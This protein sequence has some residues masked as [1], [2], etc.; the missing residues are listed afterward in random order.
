MTRSALSKE[1]Y[2]QELFNQ[3][4]EEKMSQYLLEIIVYFIYIL[5]LLFIFITILRTNDYK[6]RK[7]ITTD[8]IL[9]LG[10]T[11]ITLII[12][13]GKTNGILQN[14]DLSVTKLRMIFASIAFSVML[15]T[16][17]IRLKISKKGK[18]YETKTPLIFNLNYKDI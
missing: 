3:R 7:I 6:D 15:V 5:S 11:I 17:I 2:I 10:F 8:L 9:S 18:R 13:S 1:R 12:T 16:V 4:K 14:T